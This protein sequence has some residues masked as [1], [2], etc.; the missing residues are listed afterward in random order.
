MTFPRISPGAVL[1]VATA[2]LVA[3]ALAIVY[4]APPSRWS[5][6]QDFDTL[7][8][9]LA[10]GFGFTKATA[11][12]RDVSMEREPGYPVFL[13]LLYRVGG[14]RPGWAMVVQVLLHA[15]TAVFAWQT[16]TRLFGRRA[17][18]LAGFVTALHP[19][20]AAYTGYLLSESLLTFLV[21]LSAWLWL[22]AVARRGVAWFT[23]LGMCLGASTL[24]R[25]ALLLLGV[26]VALLTAWLFRSRPRLAGTLAASLALGAFLPVAGW[27]ARNYARFGTPQLRM[28]SGAVLWVRALDLG[29]P[30]LPRTLAPSAW[31]RRTH[32]K[33]TLYRQRRDAALAGASDWT[34]AQ[35]AFDRQLAREAAARMLRYPLDLAYSAVGELVKFFF[36]T[37]SG[38]PNLD[39]FR[40]RFAA[41]GFAA[42]LLRL[43]LPLLTAGALVPFAACAILA[44]SARRGGAPAGPAG[45]AY[46]VGLLGYVTV[47]NALV[48]TIGR[49][50]VPIYPALIVLAAAGAV[51][52][53]S[54]LPHRAAQASAGEVPT[55]P[56]PRS[57]DPVAASEAA[58]R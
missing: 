13:A 32:E 49:Y 12:P 45:A 11:P 35:L 42:M 46:L 20:L 26:V 3:A 51:A 50:A 15:A 47:S 23:A 48:D 17:G 5:D 8:W 57:G 54:R 56:Q 27:A 39:A 34:A 36:T 40:A 7:A 30:A 38:T 9:N 25:S 58:R 43:G 28:N 2:L 4:Q 21:T 41:A 44:R 16:G 10:Q 29:T 1:L 53:A 14:H 52:L 6:A 22:E 18:W 31:M 33:W 55:G 19:T 24:T 37:H